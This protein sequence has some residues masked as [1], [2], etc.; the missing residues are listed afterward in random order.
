MTSLPTLDLRRATSV[1]QA[2]A[3]RLE[4][5][6]SRLLGG[7]TDLI[8]NLRRGIGDHPGALIDVNGIAEMT[9]IEGA[10]AGDGASLRIGAAAKLATLAA[11]PLVRDRY[12]VL[13]QAAG[14]IAGATHRNMG[15]LG[16]NLCLDTRCIF[17]NQSA[18]WRASNDHCLKYGG[19]KCHVAPKSKTCFATFSGDL[20][21]ALL[22][23]D[24]EVEIAGHGGRRSLPLAQLYT[25]DGRDY[26]SL[27][28]EE[29]VCSVTLGTNLGAPPG[30]RSGYDKIRVRRSIE[31]PLAGV[32]VA[33]R[34][35][36]DLLTDLRVA[37]TGTNP[38]PVLL[39]GTDEIC[40]G[41]LDE[42]ALA[43]FDALVS[44][45]VMAMKTTFTPGHYRRRVAAV[46]ARRL[47]R[48]LFDSG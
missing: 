34:R 11:H 8:V 16:G 30:L 9:A 33:L 21:P 40:G 26:L 24:A 28:A 10:G 32:A 43:R 41:G 39:E 13:A 37:I 14:S 22:V 27:G 46:L 2:I 6:D 29:I 1:E 47:M 18:W 7:G 3:W 25:R 45:Q 23:L 44:R 20:A 31:F 17:Y 4:K 19:S 38:W 35:E 48:R 15:T 42:A 36:G 5:P 12:P